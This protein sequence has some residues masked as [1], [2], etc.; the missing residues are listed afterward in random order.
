[1]DAQRVRIISRCIPSAGGPLP[2]ARCEFSLLFPL[3]AWYVDSAQPPRRG[4]GIGGREFSASSSSL[5]DAPS[6]PS[7]LSSSTPTPPKMSDVLLTPAE[8]VKRKRAGSAAKK[9]T[10]TQSTAKQSS[11]SRVT[12]TTKPRR[13]KAIAALPP[14]PDSLPRIRA[15]QKKVPFVEIE[16]PEPRAEPVDTVIA[17]SEKGVVE[18]VGKICLIQGI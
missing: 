13:R 18:P 9:A 11:P 4:G 6:P 5:S 15:K 7:P 12:P 16:V 8:T 17:S 3:S 1:M 2:S 14:R 10:A